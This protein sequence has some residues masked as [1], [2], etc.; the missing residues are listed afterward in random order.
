MTELKREKRMRRTMDIIEALELVIGEYRC[1][2]AAMWRLEASAEWD[3]V[4]YVRYVS[5][6]CW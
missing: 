3:N 1:G 4:G 6:A 5:L 2:K